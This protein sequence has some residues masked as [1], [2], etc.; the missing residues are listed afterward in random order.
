MNRP[1][2][3]FISCVI[4]AYNEA[5]NLEPLL[6]ELFGILPALSPRCEVLVIDD[7]STDRTVAV[8]EPLTRRWP[9]RLICLSRNFGKEAAL[10]AGLDH[11][12]DDVV[13]LMDADLQHP[14]Q[15]LASMFECWRAGFDMITALRVSRDGDGWMRRFLTRRFYALM[16]RLTATPIASGAGDFRLMSRPVAEALRQLPERS[17]FMKG[18]YAWVGF[19]STTVPYEPRERVHGRSRFLLRPLFRLARVG[20]ISFSDLPL[21]VWTGVGAAVSLAAIA[22]GLYLLV[23]VL[24]WGRDVPGWITVVVSVLLPGGLQLLSI[25]VLGEYL[26]EVFKEVKRRPSYVVARRIE[27]A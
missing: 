26:A 21:R 2:C 13:V 24:V 25:G 18:L 20:L 6:A 7:G 27:A 12:R 8:V 19:P 17:R 3:P 10:T 1:A 15:L 5:Q 23:A 9:V 22:Y 14:P 16:G 11:A 4:P